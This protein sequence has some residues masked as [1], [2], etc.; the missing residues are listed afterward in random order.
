MARWSSRAWMA[1]S[2]SARAVSRCWRK[3]GMSEGEVVAVGFGGHGRPVRA[4]GQVRRVLLVP[5]ALYSVEGAIGGQVRRWHF[6]VYLSQLVPGLGQVR[7]V[8]RGVVHA[9]EAFGGALASLWALGELGFVAADEFP[10]DG[11]DVG[12]AHAGAF[13]DLG[14]GEPVVGECLANH[15][16]V[17]DWFAGLAECEQAELFVECEGVGGGLEFG[18]RAG[19]GMAEDALGPVRVGPFEGESRVGGVVDVAAAAV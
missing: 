6:F 7:G 2:R 8:V 15:V 3:S 10:E 1:R 16:G 19:F 9:A 5:L 14:D 4:V 12:A 17:C 18:A 11:L 13:G